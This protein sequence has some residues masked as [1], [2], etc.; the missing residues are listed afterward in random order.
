MGLVYRSPTDHD[1]ELLW[2]IN[3][4]GLGKVVREEFNVSARQHRD[5]FD[6]HFRLSQNLQIIVVE[7]EDAGYLA[8]ER[9]DDHIYVSGLVLLPPF[10]RRG[11]G[12]KIMRS[13]T[14]EASASGSDV[15]LQVL[16]SNP[17]RWFYEKLGF[18]V[19]TE[20]E[21]HY[22]MVKHCRN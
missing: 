3:S 12:T 18:I 13:I 5:F 6:E 22:Q 14:N 19:E 21:H 1:W 8:H 4:A 2:R 15:R 10:Q 9:R 16:K 7:G 20:T 17:A 11:I